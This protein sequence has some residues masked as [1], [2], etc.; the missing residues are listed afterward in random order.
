MKFKN[1]NYPILIAATH[2]SELNAVEHTADGIRFGVS[3]T[4]TT[5]EDVLKEAIDTLPGTYTVYTMDSVALYVRIL[6]ALHCTNEAKSPLTTIQ[7][8]PSS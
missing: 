7:G 8:L 4:L 5:L 6:V 1:Q 3:V 2:I